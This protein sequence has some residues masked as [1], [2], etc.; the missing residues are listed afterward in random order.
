[1]AYATGN[2]DTID[3]LLEAIQSAASAAGW[4]VNRSGALGAGDMAGR[5]CILENGD[6]HV[7]LRSAAMINSILPSSLNL[8]GPG[9]AIA[10]NAGYDSGEDWDAQPGRHVGRTPYVGPQPTNNQDG[11]F[12]PE[13]RNIEWPATYHLFTFDDPDVVV[14]VLRMS[15]TRY[16]YLMFG[17]TVKYG[18]WTGGWFVSAS[19]AAQSTT[20]GNFSQTT[21]FSIN[22]NSNQRSFAPFMRM[23]TNLNDGKVA[24]NVS[25][26]YMR[27]DVG[28]SGDIDADPWTYCAISNANLSGDTPRREGVWNPYKVPISSRS[29]VAF[30]QVAVMVPYAIVTQRDDHHAVLARLAHVRHLPI[31]NFA[32]G[33]VF[34]LGPDQ[35]MVFPYFEKNGITGRF[36]WAIKYEPE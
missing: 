13:W 5:E 15:P 9:L 16:Q 33:D 24:D 4:T 12:E 26:S 28:E 35:W 25:N 6:A 23:R 32:G 7:S 20:T 30:N 18:T 14:C 36:G 3:D 1:M 8:N 2:A 34:T 22:G 21:N 29:P 27:C 31:D 19:G 10:G 11:V 17:E